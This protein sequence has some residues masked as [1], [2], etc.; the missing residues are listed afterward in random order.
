MPN[1][2]FFIDKSDFDTILKTCNSTEIPPK[3]SKKAHKIMLIEIFF[4][5]TAVTSD[6]PF[7]SSIMPENIGFAKDKSILSNFSIGYKVADSISS[8]LLVFKIDI[9]TEN[10]TTNPPIIIIVLLASK[11]DSERI[12]PKFLKSQ[13]ILFFCCKWE[14]VVEEDS[15]FFLENKPKIKP[16]VIA[17]NT[18]VIKST[19]PIVEFANM[20]IPNSS[21]N[22]QRT[23]IIGKT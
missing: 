15:A 9:T 1:I 3:P 11:I 21:N 23:R 2:Y 18:C 22:K 13:L 14:Y 16:T 6:R 5:D 19:R 4:V 10:I 20:L 8:A 17:D 7:V 12:A